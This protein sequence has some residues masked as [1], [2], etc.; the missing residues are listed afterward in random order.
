MRGSSLANL[1]LGLQERKQ[2][3]ND[4]GAKNT[5]GKTPRRRN[6]RRRAMAADTRVARESR[7]ARREASHRLPRKISAKPHST[8]AAE[9]RAVQVPPKNLDAR[10]AAARRADDVAGAGASR[11]DALNRGNTLQLFCKRNMAGSHSL[12]SPSSASSESSPSSSSSLSCTRTR[13]ASWSVS[14]AMPGL[15]D[16]SWAAASSTKSSAG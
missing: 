4:E 14:Y 3:S 9:A 15:S 8:R 2:D 7:S 16:A 13:R 6:T 12:S 1:F 5:K 10:D 11:R